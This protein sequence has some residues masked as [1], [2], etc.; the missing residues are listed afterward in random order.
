M[1]ILA[2][3]AAPAD[4]SSYLTFLRFCSPPFIRCTRNLRSL[5]RASTELFAT[6]EGFIQQGQATKHETQKL[7]KLLKPHIQKTLETFQGGVSVPTNLQTTTPSG[8]KGERLDFELPYMSKFLL[9]AAYIASQ[10]RPSSDKRQF[11]MLGSRSRKRGRISTS[12]S[13]KQ[14]VAATAAMLAGPGSFDGERLLAIFWFI[15]N[16]EEGSEETCSAFNTQSSEVFMQISSLVSLRLLSKVSC[17]NS[18]EKCK[19]RCNVSDELANRLARNLKV[20]LH[21]YLIYV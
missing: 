9:L 6:Y 3:T 10:N 7:F 21:K 1:Q 13:D 2:N 14:A 16:N 15:L 18:L 19:Y 20:E 17:D 5:H 4:R 8:A 11:D 12:R